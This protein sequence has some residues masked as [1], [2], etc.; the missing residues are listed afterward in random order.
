[1]NKKNIKRIIL[2]TSL[3]L[4]IS[5]ASLINAYAATY[6]AVSG[7]SLYKISIIFNTTVAQLMID[8]Q[9]TTYNLNIGQKIFVPC[10][11]YIV[12]KGDSL[13][14][15]SQ[16]FNISL[17]ELRRANN[18]YTN[19]ILVGQELN[20]PKTASD[21]TTTSTSSAD[22]KVIETPAVSTTQ[23]ITAAP[24][25]AAAPEVSPTPAVAA[26]PEASVAPKIAA[27]P[28]VPV[29]PEVITAPS[30]T[31]SDLDLLSRLI[32][33]EA[34]GEP[35]EAKVAVGAAVMNRVQSDLWPNSVYEVIY[36]NINGYYQFT[37]VLN[38]WINKPANDDSIK[39]AKEAFDGTDPTNGAMFYY[40]TSTT[41]PWM[42][43]KPVS[44]TAGKMIFAH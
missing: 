41:N 40:D 19:Y 13:Y 28:V 38:G 1:M 6:T 37:P 9:L 11:S 22:K 31:A 24:K 35:Y 33:A 3:A 7:D 16:K 5:L 34:Q 14:L 8:N 30:Y 25:V 44:Y 15:I 17:F 10:K 2:T 20:I 18:I 43:A 39:A 27:A 12:Q 36:Q 29:A 4:S 21:A 42:L 23:T 32:M 26:I